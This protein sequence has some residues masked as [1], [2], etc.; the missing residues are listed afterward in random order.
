MILYEYPQASTFG[1]VVPKQKIYE[2]GSVSP[3]MRELFAA[4]VE[5]IRWQ[6]K[7]A[8]ETINVKATQ[9]VPEIQVF[10]VAL[11]GEEISPNALKCIDDAIPLPL[12][13]E[14]QKGN[15]LQIA[16]AP[17]VLTGG[18]VLCGEYYFSEWISADSVRSPLPVA[19]DLS[20][21]YG[22]LLSSLVPYPMRSGE[23]LAEW[24][25]RLNLIQEKIREA[26]KLEAKLRREKQFNRQ[27][28]INQELRKKKEEIKSLTFIKNEK[29]F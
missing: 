13:F 10:S 23:A 27:I 5:Q 17:K 14:I 8:P 25:V 11:K 29:T 18:A 21:L 15:R 7:L 19:L 2:H 26:E 6:N 24:I 9:S 22:I 28:P 1:R 16:A 4:Q 3:K 12:I 20:S